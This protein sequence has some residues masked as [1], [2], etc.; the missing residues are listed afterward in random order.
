MAR[1]TV[2]SLIE[3]FNDFQ[4]SCSSLL[5]TTKADEIYISR[6]LLWT[7]SKTYTIELPS[8][9]FSQSSNFMSEQLYTTR[10]HSVR[11]FL[12]ALK[13]DQ[14]AG[15]RALQGQWIFR[16]QIKTR[17]GPNGW[18]L[19][20][21]AG[22]NSGF[23]GGLSRSQ[24]WEKSPPAT[25]NGE[26]VA[27][28]EIQFPPHDISMFHDWCSRAIAYRSDLPSNEWERLALA[29][30]YGLAT[31]LLDWSESPLI[32]LFFAV[33]ADDMN[34]GAVYCYMRPKAQI[35]SNIHQFSSIGSN[36]P[37]S[38]RSCV[39]PM[40]RQLAYEEIALYTPRPLDQ[41]M[42]HQK[43]LFTYH[44][45]PLNP[46]LPIHEREGHSKFCSEIDRFGT[47]LMEFVIDGAWKRYLRDELRMLGF[48]RETVYPDLEGLSA[49]INHN[50]WSGTYEAR[51][52][53]P[54]PPS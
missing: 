46:I 43:A 17:S 52:T 39:D 53:F 42:L 38:L 41:R 31:R 51:A 1:F 22:R 37:I 54:N 5:F 25:V 48:D 9:C 10:I 2:W 47:D 18:P 13:L 23:A 21:K 29:Q 19:L 33:E 20:P 4:V 32:A 28:T 49:Q 16:G 15:S 30:H 14:G 24:G 35:D 40:L 8:S 44:A 3:I 7:C 50:G 12:D 6:S 45:K 11:E 34:P 36:S 27:G 26:T